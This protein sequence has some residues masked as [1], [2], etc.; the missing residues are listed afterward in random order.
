M[1]IHRITCAI[2]SGVA[3]DPEI[4]KNSIEGGTVWGLGA[5]FESNISFKDGQTVETNFN[6]FGISQVTRC[7]G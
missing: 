3:L 6:N 5:A 1:K 7:R 2:D 4:C